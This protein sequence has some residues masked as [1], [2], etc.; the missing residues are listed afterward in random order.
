MIEGGAVVVGAEGLVM[1][2]VGEE[3]Q[4]TPAVGTVVGV[5]KIQSSLTTG[6]LVSIQPVIERHFYLVLI[7][8]FG[9]SVS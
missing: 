1:P 3:G 2:A 6:R 9:E 8:L 4:V 7:F 5:V